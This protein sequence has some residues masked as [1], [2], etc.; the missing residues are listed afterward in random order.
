MGQMM[1]DICKKRMAEVRYKAKRKRGKR[2]RYIIDEGLWG[3]SWDTEVV[4]PTK[5][6]KINLCEDCAEKLFN[7]KR[8]EGN[9]DKK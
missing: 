3:K 7:S 6:E 4:W 8:R 1:C 5:W 2:V 9:G